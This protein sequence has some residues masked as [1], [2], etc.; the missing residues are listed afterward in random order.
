MR[1]IR[2][3]NDEQCMWHSATTQYAGILPVGK[4]VQPASNSG[5]AESPESKRRFKNLIEISNLYDKLQFHK[6]IHIDDM[7]LLRIHTKAYIDRFKKMSDEGG[8]EL[9]PIGDATPIGPGSYE[10]AKISAGLA[11]AAIQDVWLGKAD[12][13]YALSRPPGHHALPDQ[14]L[15]FCL[16]ANIPIAIEYCRVHHNLGKVLILDWD[17][18]HGNG[19]QAIY[20]EDPNTYTISIH[21]ENCY[22]V[23]YRGDED[24]GEG[25]GT[26][27]NLNI[28]LPAGA[29]HNA[30]LQVFDSIVIPE[31]K[32][33]QPDMIIIASGFD[34]NILD[35]LARMNLYSESYYLMMD[36][37]IKVA[38]EV[39][40][41]KVVAIHEGGYS[42]SYVPFCGIAVLEALLGERSDVVDPIVDYCI[43]KQPSEEVEAFLTQYIEKMSQKIKS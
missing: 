19:A 28:P 21:Q 8:G 41:G 34:A 1:N 3:Y 35:P 26:G 13:A 11:T 15:G 23:G 42:E 36:K 10:I 39:C 43:N 22:P 18:H 33:Y 40:H 5:L 30:Y 38:E 29:G 27:Y 24:R 37:V 4:W 31:I 12:A 20:Y 25:A 9:G 14:A 7:D 17:V 32:K 2:F 16:L 6:G